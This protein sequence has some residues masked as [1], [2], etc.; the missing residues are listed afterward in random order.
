MSR[1][2]VLVAMSAIAATAAEAIA[3]AEFPARTPARR[4]CRGDI[5]AM[6]SHHLQA[7]LAVGEIA[8][9]RRA[10]RHVAM[11]AR[12]QG[13]CMTKGVAAIVESDETVPLCGVEP[14]HLAFR[15]GLRNGLIVAVSHCEPTL[16]APCRLDTP[17]LPR[18]P[19]PRGQLR[20]DDYRNTQPATG[21]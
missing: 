4:F 17:K 21:L 3:A 12:L 19:A 11:P 5:D 15:R 18:V 6:H 2:R 14:L 13:A 8:H 7:A 10:W 1:M 9:D 16:L 20:H